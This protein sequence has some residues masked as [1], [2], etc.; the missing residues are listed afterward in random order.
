MTSNDRYQI[1]SRVHLRFFLYFRKRKS[2]KYLRAAQ[3]C[4]Q[5]QYLRTCERWNTHTSVFLPV[6]SQPAT[7]QTLLKIFFCVL[8]VLNELNRFVF[9][10]LL[11]PLKPLEMLCAECGSAAF[12][13][14]I[15]SAFFFSSAKQK[16]PLRR[17][18]KTQRRR[19]TEHKF[20]SC[21]N[22]SLP[23]CITYDLCERKGENHS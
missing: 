6:S 11:H 1:N 14:N 22:G 16:G 3:I 5:V 9:S 2:L 21:M 15:Y 18:R 12:D 8:Q 4:T 10:V 20:K 23:S 17:R 13:N 19:R 7:L